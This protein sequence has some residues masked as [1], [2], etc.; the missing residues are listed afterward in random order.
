MI[1]YLVC[2]PDRCFNSMHGL[3]QCHHVAFNGGI[4]TILVS[5]FLLWDGVTGKRPF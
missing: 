1:F 3:F 2:F 4:K 5:S